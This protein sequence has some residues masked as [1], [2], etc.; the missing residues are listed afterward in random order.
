MLGRCGTDAE[1]GVGEARRALTRKRARVSYLVGIL[2]GIRWRPAAT[3]SSGSVVN[4]GD[5]PGIW[6]ELEPG[7]IIGLNQAKYIPGGKIFLAGCRLKAV[8]ACA[9]NGTVRHG[10]RLKADRLDEWG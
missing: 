4:L 8:C 7:G 2:F 1:T 3:E 5:W 9:L 10:E 6:P